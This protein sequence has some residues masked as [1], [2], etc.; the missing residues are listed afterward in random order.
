MLNKLRTWLAAREIRHQ[1]VCRANY[2][3]AHWHKL[4]VDPLIADNDFDCNFSGGHGRI[5]YK[6]VRVCEITGYITTS[7]LNGD[8]LSSTTKVTA[9]RPGMWEPLFLELASPTVEEI[10]VKLSAKREEKKKQFSP[11]EEGD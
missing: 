9:Y 1:V 11:F 8:I 5:S 7:R 10:N 2:I 4:G 3:M 6:G